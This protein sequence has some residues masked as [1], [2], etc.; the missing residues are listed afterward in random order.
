ML[1]RADF[2]TN[3]SSDLI[4]FAGGESP[5]VAVNKPLL[6]AYNAMW[7]AAPSFEVGEPR[8]ALPHMRR[9]LAAIQKARQ[10]ER[11]YLRGNPPRVVIDIN[12]ARLQGK[13]KGTTSAR[14]ALASLDSVSRTRATRLTRIVEL[15]AHDAPAAIDSLLLLRVDALGDEPAFAAALSDAIAAMRRGKS[16]EATS[17]LGRARR[18]LAGAPIPRDSLARWGSSHERRVRVCDRA[19]RVGRL[20]YAPLVPPNIIDTVARYTEIGVAPTGVIVPLATTGCCAT[21]CST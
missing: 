4:D 18:S 10:A 19:V 20:G 15:S 9:A 6:E 21:R 12:K 2:A 1:A 16:D 11:L 7:D 17:A 13:D 5:V 14:R 8:R 3:R